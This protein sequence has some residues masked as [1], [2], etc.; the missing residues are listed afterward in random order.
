ML[1]IPKEIA[2]DCT[3]ALRIALA[4]VWAW[5]DAFGK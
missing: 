4:G 1:A 3:E 5:L 2:S